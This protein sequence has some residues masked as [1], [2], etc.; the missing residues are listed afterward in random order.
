MFGKME[1]GNAQ[2]DE[3]SAIPTSENSYIVEVSVSHGNS[4]GYYIGSIR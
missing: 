2:Q 4:S 3:F 1:K